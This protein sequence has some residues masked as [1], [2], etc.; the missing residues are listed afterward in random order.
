MDIKKLLNKIKTI[1]KEKL[2]LLA[3]AGILLIGASYFESGS[4][5]NDVEEITTVTTNS[6]KDY[7]SQMEQ[8]V[9]NLVEGIK[10]ISDVT[11]LITLKTGSEKVLKEDSENTSSEKESGTDIERNGSNKKTTVIFSQ[12]GDD[13]PYV[14][15]E[16][17]PEIEGIAITA[18]GVSES[19]YKE[20]IINMLSALFNVPVHK[21][22]VLETD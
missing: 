18:K 22:S 5:K 9:K 7:Q 14:I 8:K 21:I 17:Y 1:E 20:E 15:K 19:K 16:I 11:V 4:N 10:G 2:L 3:L 6:E 13:N 12:N